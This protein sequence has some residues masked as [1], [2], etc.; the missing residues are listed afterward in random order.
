RWAQSLMAE[1]CAAQKGR[2]RANV[3]RI[4]VLTAPRAS[5][6]ARRAPQLAHGAALLLPAS[7]FQRLTFECAVALL[8]FGALGLD[9]GVKLRLLARDGRVEFRV[10]ARHGIAECGALVLHGRLQRVDEIALTR[11]PRAAK[12]HANRSS[13]LRPQH[14]QQ[15]LQGATQRDQLVLQPLRSYQRLI[16]LRNICGLW[17]LASR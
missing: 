9:D 12:L 11:A 17:A 8:Q 7:R 10:L 2:R 5:G 3:K 6:R 1:D 13:P 16:W 15:L 4:S 14:G